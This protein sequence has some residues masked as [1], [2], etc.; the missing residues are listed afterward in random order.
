[1]FRS[2]WAEFSVNLWRPKIYRLIVFS[3]WQRTNFILMIFRSNSCCTTIVL[4]S[5]RVFVGSTARLIMLWWVFFNTFWLERMLNLSRC[6]VCVCVRVQGPGQDGGR[7]TK[8]GSVKHACPL[9]VPI[10]PAYIH[11]TSRIN[12]SSP[13]H[14]PQCYDQKESGSWRCVMTKTAPV[15]HR[16]RTRCRRTKQNIHFYLYTGVE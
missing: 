8:A 7:K 3:I 1:M 9:C 4:A 6:G 13:V 16:R 15:C 5:S 11:D 12:F 14:V 2:C 10:N